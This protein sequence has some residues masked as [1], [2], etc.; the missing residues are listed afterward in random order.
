MENTLEKPDQT[1]SKAECHRC[2][3][4]VRDAL[5][6]L[7]GK[8]KLLILSA[9][10]DGPK[11]FRELQRIVEGIT[12]KLLSK[13]LKELEMNEFI[14]RRVYPSL[15]VLIEYE[16]ADYGTSLDAVIKTLGQWGLEHRA[17]IQSR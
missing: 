1:L 7:N 9:L 16:L 15:P 4:G 17:R 11:R 5:Y 2:L 10:R 12:P 3:D 8:W 6:V 13:E 14:T